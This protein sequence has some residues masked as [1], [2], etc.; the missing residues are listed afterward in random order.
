M[1]QDKKEKCPQKPSCQVPA[2]GTGLL[3]GAHSPGRI[4]SAPSQLGHPE[5]QAVAVRGQGLLARACPLPGK[6]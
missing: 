3:P 5:T 1:V 4:R 6:Q 2:L